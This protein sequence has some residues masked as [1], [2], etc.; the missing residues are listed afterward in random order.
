MRK[1]SP[2]LIFLNRIKIGKDKLKDLK[3]KFQY[4]DFQKSERDFAFVMDKNFEVQE[5]IKIITDVDKDLI[6]SIRVFDVY[7]GENI[8]KDKKSVALNVTIQSSKKS[9]T[10]EDLNNLNRLIISSVEN[11]TGAKLRS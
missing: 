7:E 3:S 6:K 4:S 8:D 1:S 10:E 2:H 5:L 11:K 9:L